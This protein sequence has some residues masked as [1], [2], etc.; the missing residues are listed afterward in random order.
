MVPAKHKKET[1]IL[2][3]ILRL[4]TV[5][6]SITGHPNI[7]TN[8]CIS[9]MLNTFHV[10][11]LHSE[12]RFTRSMPCP[13]RAHAV[14]LPRCSLIYTCHAALLPCSNSAVIFTKVR[15]VAGNIQTDSPTVKQIVFLQC[16][17]TTLYSHRYGIL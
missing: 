4:S 12:G 7:I 13:C 5:T 14:P 6:V 15:V 1:A 3:V 2:L 11:P 9:Y 17:A 10:Q 8:C 16:A